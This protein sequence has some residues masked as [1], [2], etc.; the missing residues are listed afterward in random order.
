MDVGSKNKIEQ[1]STITKENY[2]GHTFEFETNVG[3]T[4]ND[5]NAIIE[6]AASDIEILASFKN[7]KKISVERDGCRI[8]N[9]LGSGIINKESLPKL[10]V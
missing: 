2:K 8:Y 9:L 10:N 7:I 5:K 4:D 6:Q 3:L 1:Q